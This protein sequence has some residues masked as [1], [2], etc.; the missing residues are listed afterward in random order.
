MNELDLTFVDET[1]ERTGTGRENVLAILQAVQ[2]HYGYLPTQALEQVCRLTEISPASIAGVSSFYDRFRFHPAGR[3]T[4]RVCIGTACHVKGAAQIYDAFRR[5]LN[6]PEDN[7]TD[8]DKMFTVEKVPCLG[9]CMLAPAVQISDIIFGHLTS[10][11][12]PSV[13]KDFLEEQKT[14]QEQELSL[15]HISEPTRPY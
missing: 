9:C 13:L 6:I 11:K 14:R 3:Y 10:Q 7:D 2:G 1:V 8:A 12:V 5:H 4:I 15:I